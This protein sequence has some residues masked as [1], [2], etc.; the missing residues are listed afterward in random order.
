MPR[1]RPKTAL[2]RPM[3]RPS[4]P[5]AVP[6]P[7]EPFMDGMELRRI[8]E[9]YGLDNLQL[10]LALIAEQ[11]RR[12][13]V[14]RRCR[15]TQDAWKENARPIAPVS[16]PSAVAGRQWHR[17]TQTLEQHLDNVIYQRARVRELED[18][19]AL[20]LDELGDGSLACLRKKAQL[21]EIVSRIRDG[22]TAAQIASALHISETT[23]ENRLAELRKATRE[24]VESAS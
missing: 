5:R 15:D 21:R 23:V 3:Y 24:K 16:I 11:Q 20:M 9:R 6:E 22:D 4:A 10:A 2:D 17:R 12:E 7:L 1:K 8:V 18:G 13:M 14:A 19:L